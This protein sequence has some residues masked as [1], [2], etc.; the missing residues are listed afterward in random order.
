MLLSEYNGLHCVQPDSEVG[1]PG[2]THK[3]SLCSLHCAEALNASDQGMC[4]SVEGAEP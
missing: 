4:Q 1:L 2:C 3:L